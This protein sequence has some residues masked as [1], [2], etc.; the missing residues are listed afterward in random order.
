MI[1]YIKGKVLTAIENVV[2]L[3]NNG[4]GYEITCSTS[5]LASLTE[6]GE[7]AVYTYMAVREDGVSLYGFSSMEEKT[8]FLSLITVS[9]VGPK[10]GI[11]I[12]SG[13]RLNELLYAIAISDVKSL[14]KVKGLGKKTAERIIL[15]LREKVGEIAEPKS[16]KKNAEEEKA[17]KAQNED[18]VIALMSLGFTKVESVNAVIEAENSGAKNIE[19]LIAYAIKHIK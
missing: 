9:G 8:A 16:A 5:A 2:I 17:V 11:T 14:S 19:E 4:I 7:G 3:E 1:G 15:E 10:M 6:K 12:L 13:M 18:A